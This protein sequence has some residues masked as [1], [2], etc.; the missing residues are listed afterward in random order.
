M[1]KIVASIPMEVTLLNASQSWYP[2]EKW[3]NLAIHGTFLYHHG[4]L[5]HLLMKQLL[6]NISKTFI[7]YGF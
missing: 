3:A 1:N 2:V 7:N 5:E 4:G 6:I